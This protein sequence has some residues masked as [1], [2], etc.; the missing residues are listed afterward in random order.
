V[1]ARLEAY[2]HEHIPLSR[3]M[4]IAVVA[5]SAEELVVRCPLGPNINHRGSAFGGSIA[6]LSTLA[7]WGW[8]WVLLRAD[9]RPVTIVVSRAEIDYLKPGLGDFEARLVV[10]DSAEFVRVFERKGRARIALEAAVSEGGV[11]IARFRGEFVAK[12]G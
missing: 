7:G 2:L 9:E 3:A 1:R 11:E 4:E 6:S 10:P 12:A 8:V 5:A